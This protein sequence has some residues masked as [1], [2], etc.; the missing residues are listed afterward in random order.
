[1]LIRSPP[2]QGRGIHSLMDIG[3]SVSGN[4]IS[5]PR[6]ELALTAYRVVSPTPRVLATP[7][8]SLDLTPTIEVT[9]SSFYDLKHAALRLQTVGFESYVH[10]TA[11]P[12]LAVGSADG[13]RT[14]RDMRSH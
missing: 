14:H 6:L 5:V 7:A 1:M 13:C 10:G 12:T 8:T 4:P 9:L 2:C 3:A 11:E